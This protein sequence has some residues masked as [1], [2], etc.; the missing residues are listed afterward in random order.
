MKRAFLCIVLLVSSCVFASDDYSGFYHSSGLW[1]DQS[2]GNATITVHNRRGEVTDSVTFAVDDNGSP[3]GDWGKDLFGQTQEGAVAIQA[4]EEA[5]RAQIMT[6]NFA[7]NLALLMGNGGIVVKNAIKSPDGTF[8]DLTISI[9]PNQWENMT[10]GDMIRGE[11]GDSVNE[12]SEATIDGVSLAAKS[13]GD[14]EVNGWSTVAAEGY[15]VAQVLSDDASLNN[16]SLKDVEV[17]VRT[18]RGYPPAFLRIG[19]G[20]VPAGTNV[21]GE[22][23]TTNANEGA[24]AG[25]SVSLHGW[26]AA[27]S[28]ASANDPQLPFTMGAGLSWLGLG[29]F[30]DGETVIK[31]LTDSKL[32]IKGWTSAMG[33]RHYFGTGE[34]DGVAGWYELPNAVTN[35]VEGDEVT[36]TSSTVGDVKTLKLKGW[37]VLPTFD[38]QNPTFVVKNQDGSIGSMPL[39]MAATNVSACVCSQKWEQVDA[40]T[41]WNFSE[42]G[43]SVEFGVPDGWLDGSVFSKD[44]DGRLVL[45]GWNS[46]ICYENLGDMI[47]GNGPGA[48]G[49]H[50]LLSWFDDGNVRQLHYINIGSIATPDSSQFSVGSDNK[51]TIAGYSSNSGKFL[52]STGSGLTWADAGGGPGIVEVDN[53]SIVSNDVGQISVKGFSGADENTVATKSSGSVVWKSLEGSDG[54]TVE[55]GHK[56]KGS[57]IGSGGITVQGNTISFDDDGEYQSIEIVTDV[58]WD[59]NSHSLKVTKVSLPIKVQKGFATTPV[60]STVFTAVSHDAEYGS[61]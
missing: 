19:S 60:Q 16:E 23:V 8:R 13:N 61:N 47:A 29:G 18:G 14:I 40:W 5:L 45:T 12:S 44:P 27:K 11:A 49:Q 4:L 9:D 53:A 26:S 17:M 43:S 21:D 2:I 10:K 30:V 54:V 7:R 31:S 58:T 33:N 6:D 57:Y 50:R 25:G 38:P 34:A 56:I 36:I 39:A 37:E 15:T 55:Y 35:R 52:K 1:Y 32:S 28:A 42:D 51:F 59:E 22:S 41:G 3:I 48:A 20:I 24:V 46:P